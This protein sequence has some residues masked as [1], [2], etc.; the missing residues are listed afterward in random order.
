MHPLAA[1]DFVSCALPIMHTTTSLGTITQEMIASHGWGSKVKGHTT[2]SML[3]AHT[4]LTPHCSTLHLLSHDLCPLCGFVS[5]ALS[6]WDSTA[7]TCTRTH[8]H[9]HTC[10]RTHT[11]AHTHTHTCTRTHTHT[12]TCTH[13]PPP[14]A[15]QHVQ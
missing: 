12:C 1:L 13:T 10:T 15:I 3:Q 8:T 7:M 14:L 2:H 4:A 6:S 11:H 9:T 5:S